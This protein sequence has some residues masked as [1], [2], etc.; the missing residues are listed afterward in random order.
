MKLNSQKAIDGWQIKSRFDWIFT[1]ASFVVFL[2]LE[3]AL[4]YAYFN[5]LNQNIK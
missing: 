3:A 2:C 4:L 1:G 5:W